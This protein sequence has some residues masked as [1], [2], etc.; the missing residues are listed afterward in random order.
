MKIS[1]IFPVVAE[2]PIKE[3]FTDF[4]TKSVFSK[5]K[6]KETF[7]VVEKNDEE[8]I[9][10]LNSLAIR[11][12]GI[13]IIITEK[14]VESAV[15]LRLCM[16]YISGDVALLGDTKTE[17]LDLIFEKMLA[18]QEKG[19]N[20]VHIN[21]KHSKFKEI[22]NK[23]GNVV[24]NFLVKLFTGKKDSGC[25]T[26]IVL[27][28]KLV[29][30]VL[31]VLPEKSNFLRI[32]KDLEGINIKAVY[33]DNKMSVEKIDYKRNTPSLIATYVLTG[34]IGACLL[35]VLFVNIFAKTNLLGFNLIVCGII[36]VCLVAFIIAISK[37][38]LD[39]RT[40]NYKDNEN[41]D[42]VNLKK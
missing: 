3:F 17:K 24:Y 30:D 38:I 6:E 13:K 9:K 16:P 33:I 31:S 18:K 15:A 12:E 7:F 40:G 8:T 21:K 20:I 28:D 5:Q 29:I 22:F 4:K 10:Y 2:K 42:V 11:D 26:S 36:F 1:Y 41:Y 14:K 23:C 39:V 25:V 27:L 32:S 34:I 35:S 19:A 37:H